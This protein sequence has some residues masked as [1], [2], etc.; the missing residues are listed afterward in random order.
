MECSN[1]PPEHIMNVPVSQMLRK[2]AE[3]TKEVV[4][5]FKI[6][7]QELSRMVVNRE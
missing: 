7:P 3:A 4:E 1:R 6:A 5:D 2:S